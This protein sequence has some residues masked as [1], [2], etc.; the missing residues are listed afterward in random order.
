MK[1]INSKSMRQYILSL[2]PPIEDV[3]KNRLPHD[4]KIMFDGWADHKVHFV[5]VFANY[6]FEGK[7]EE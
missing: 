1:Q 2:V 5:E 7:Y 6:V 4:F 3:I